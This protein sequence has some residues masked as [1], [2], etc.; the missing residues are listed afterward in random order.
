MPKSR[1]KDGLEFDKDSWVITLYNT[2]SDELSGQII[3]HAALWIEGVQPDGKTVCY[4]TDINVHSLWGSLKHYLTSSKWTLLQKHQERLSSAEGYKNTIVGINCLEFKDPAYPEHRKLEQ[5]KTAKSWSVSEE[6]ALEMLRDIEDQKKAIRRQ[7]VA[8]SERILD[9]K[10]PN[11]KEYFTL[12]KLFGSKS[13]V[14]KEGNNE[15]VNCIKWCEEKLALADIKLA[16]G[17]AESIVAHPESRIPGGRCDS[18][19]AESQPE[20][21]E[22]SCRLM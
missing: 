6:K 9:N 11:P 20:S 5:Y 4:S 10:T 21:S 2:E 22:F 13:I 15:G 17:S 3:G 19:P 12:F 18:G 1:F 14:Y 7:I 8:F 16:P